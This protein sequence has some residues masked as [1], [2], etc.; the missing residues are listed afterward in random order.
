MF[1]DRKERE[2]VVTEPKP[3]GRSPVLNPASLSSKHPRA[4][5]PAQRSEAGGHRSQAKGRRHK[6]G[7][8]RIS[9][10]STHWM[11]EHDQISLDSPATLPPFRKNSSGCGRTKFVE[12]KQFGRT[13]MQV[14]RLTFGCGAVGGLMTKGEP[15]DQI[16]PWPGRAIMASTSSTRLRATATARPSA[17]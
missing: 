9:A 17:I 8:S 1:V 4:C 3:L 16:A 11:T 12:T 14:S 5:A 10:S 15:A 7:H 6:P 13:D 2:S